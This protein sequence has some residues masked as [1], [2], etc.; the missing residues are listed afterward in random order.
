MVL[1]LAR[2]PVRPEK[3]EDYIKK[4]RPAIEG[5]RKE[6]G[7]ISYDLYKSTENDSDLLYVERW[8]DMDAFDAHKEM[9]HLVAFRNIQ[10][11]EDMLAG[12]REIKVYKIAE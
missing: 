5:S 8:K 1:V 12:D 9:P 6:A 10:A 4:A 7:N 2:I 3:R 11:D